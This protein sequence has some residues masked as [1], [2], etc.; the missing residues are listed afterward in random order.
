MISN[1]SKALLIG[2]VLMA[3]V[4]V[5]TAMI[6]ENVRPL[7][8]GFL[9]VAAS[10]ELACQWLARLMGVTIFLLA[11]LG[12]ITAEGSTVQAF[13]MR[14]V[15]ALLGLAL[16]YPHWALATGASVIAVALVVTDAITRHRAA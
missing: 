15:A 12:G 13:R 5:F 3:A 2:L 11:M 9:D 8:G 10:V 16:A 7:T 6:R 14:I 1:L 4:I